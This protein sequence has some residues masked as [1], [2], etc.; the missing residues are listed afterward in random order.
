MLELFKFFHQIR[1]GDAIGRQMDIFRQPLKHQITPS[2]SRFWSQ[3]DNPVSTF[4]NVH[5]VRCKSQYFL[6]QLMPEKMP[7]IF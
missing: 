6:E 2:I 1:T 3:I 7:S 5:C 4:D